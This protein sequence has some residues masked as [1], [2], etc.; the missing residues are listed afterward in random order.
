MLRFNKKTEYALLAIEHIAIKGPSANNGVV[1][2]VREISEVYHIPFPVLAKV[3]Q[4]LAS[5]GLIKATQGI[6]GGYQ[7]AK[8]S[9]NISL[10]DLVEIFDGPL[11]VAEC[12]KK[13]RISCPQWSDCTIKNP[14][15]LLNQ[16]I[17]K[18]LT[19]TTIADLAMKNDGRI[20]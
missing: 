19:E 20:V 4:R 2:S 18:L 13:E 7:L 1:S 3:M 16:K 9:D 15:M 6:N 14:F 10:A 12:F 11:A 8:P 17:Q 5:Q